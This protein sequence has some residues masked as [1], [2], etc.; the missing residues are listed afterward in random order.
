MDNPLMPVRM[1]RLLRPLL[2]LVLAAL[3][4]S[5]FGQCSMCGTVGQGAEDPLVRGMFVSTLVMVSMPFTVVALVGGW[6]Y[7]KFRRG[8]FDPPE[9]EGSEE[10]R[11]VT[12]RRD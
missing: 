4:A 7:Y 6:F 12:F 2:A 1:G 10:D 8:A 5:A 3:P 9:Q 11:V